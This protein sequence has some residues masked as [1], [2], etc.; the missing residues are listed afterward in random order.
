M[1]RVREWGK[2]E[3]REE[4]RGVDEGFGVWV[5]CMCILKQVERRAEKEGSKE[6]G[7]DLMF[8]VS[9]LT[10]IRVSAFG[11]KVDKI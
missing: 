11:S 2:A 6:R 5:Y 10:L 1:S 9:C 8:R 4:M 7:E 3:G